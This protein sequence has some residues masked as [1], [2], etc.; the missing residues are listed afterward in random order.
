MHIIVV[1]VEKIPVEKYGHLHGNARLTAFRELAGPRERHWIG[2][3]RSVQPHGFN[4]QFGGNRQ[5]ARRKARLPRR[6]RPGKPAPSENAGA[7][8]EPASSNGNPLVKKEVWVE[9]GKTQVSESQGPGSVPRSRLSHLLR[10]NGPEQRKKTLSEWSLKACSRLLRW[11]EEHTSRAEHGDDLGEVTRELRAEI[12]KGRP[13]RLKEAEQRQDRFIKVLHVHEKSRGTNLRAVLHKPE[14]LALHPNREEANTLRVCDK[15]TPPIRTV[16][17]NFTEAAL[18]LPAEISLD[19]AEECPCRKLLPKCQDLVEGHVVTVDYGQIQ[20]KALRC[21]LEQGSK[22]RLNTHFVDSLQAIRNGLEEYIKRKKDPDGYERWKEAILQQCKA[23]LTS[24]N[25]PPIQPEFRGWRNALSDLQT[26]MVVAPVDKAPHDFAIVCRKWYQARLLREIESESYER[27]E[28]TKADILNDHRLFCESHGYEAMVD[29]LPY[30]YANVKM[31][32]KPPGLRF[33]AGVSR[34]TEQFKEEGEKDRESEVKQRPACSTTPVSQRISLLL[35]AVIESLRRKDMQF[36]KSTNRRRF[37]IIQ[38]F[39]EVALDLKQKDELLK[40][41]VPHTVDFTTMYTKLLHAQLLEN[42]K[43]AVIEAREFA[44][45]F[46]AAPDTRQERGELRVGEG[47]WTYDPDAGLSVDRLMELVAWV[48]GN[49]YIQ[50]GERILRQKIGIPMGTNCAPELAN[51]FCYSVEARYVDSHPD[52][53]HEFTYRFIDD[54]LTTEPEGLPTPAEYGLEY[55]ETPAGPD[56]SR[57][58]LGMKVLV[59]KDGTWKV[60]VADKRDSFPFPVLRYPAAIS[61]IPL[62]QARG[63]FIGQLVRYG[64]ICNNF[65]DFKDA[66][67]RLTVRMLERGHATGPLV[68]SWNA[69][70]MSRWDANDVRSMRLRGWF[71]SMLTWIRHHCVRQRD[72]REA[73][74]RALRKAGST[75]SRGSVPARR[76]RS[77]KGPP[78]RDPVAPRPPVLAPAPAPAEL[79]RPGPPAAPV[80]ALPGAGDHDVIEEEVGGS[81]SQS[82]DNQTGGEQG[83]QAV[84]ERSCPRCGKTFKSPQGLAVHLRRSVD[85]PAS[86]AFGHSA[87]RELSQLLD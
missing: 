28:R 35:E 23:N 31:H 48:V 20:H 7:S 11:I 32:K 27:V 36:F 39:E 53:R 79:G 64:T 74:G 41:R 26:C 83:R 75:P 8:G 54:I 44:K 55:A 3:L 60:G 71:K 77:R 42:V 69:Y 15:C 82:D 4:V 61:N 50:C 16:V 47:G 14:I 84:P 19:H 72:G 45:T 58:Y 33:I 68:H 87:N 46:T 81:Y 13:R 52:C 30:F 5:A 22:M 57:T 24:H 49:T 62:H 12:D 67:Q 34:K 65:Q 9:G 80:P 6:L 43:Q 1:P 37:W 56:G 17:C 40:G 25:E 70:L 51:L 66:T 85:C 73:G 59:D 86:K 10:A 21:L 78:R 76:G 29:N 2:R 18:N 38:T 63:V